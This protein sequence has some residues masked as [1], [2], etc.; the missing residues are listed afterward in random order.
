MS[1]LVLKAKPKITFVSTTQS[2]QNGDGRNWIL[3][4]LKHNS[5]YPSRRFFECKEKDDNLVLFAD[6]ILLEWRTFGTISFGVLLQWCVGYALTPIL[7]K[8]IQ[9][10]E[11]AGFVAFETSKNVMKML[12]EGGEGGLLL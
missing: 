7:S 4:L 6:L 8:L 1:N 10:F 11:K 9:L 3:S 2:G 5:N 12:G